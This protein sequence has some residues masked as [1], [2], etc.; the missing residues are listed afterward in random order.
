MQN[1]CKYKKKGNRQLSKMKIFAKSSPIFKNIP[2]GVNICLQL[3]LTPDIS[4]T[5]YLVQYLICNQVQSAI[6]DSNII[7]GSV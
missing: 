1:G 7:S 3:M 2:T 5:L 4:W 6:Y